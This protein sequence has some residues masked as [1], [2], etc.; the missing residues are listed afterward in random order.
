MLDDIKCKDKGSTEGGRQTVIRWGLEGEQVDLW[1]RLG[2]DETAFGI[3]WDGE[4]SGD[5]G[6][7]GGSEQLR[8]AVSVFLCLNREMVLLSWLRWA[9]LTSECS[10]AGSRD[11]I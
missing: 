6:H 3:D 9:V 1:G 4:E 7:V 5:W 8:Y 11:L 2:A 10:A